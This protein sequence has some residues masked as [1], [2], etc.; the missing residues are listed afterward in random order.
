M[1]KRSAD[2][3]AGVLHRRVFGTLDRATNLELPNSL[4]WGPTLPNY[5]EGSSPKLELGIGALP[6]KQGYVWGAEI[7]KIAYN[8][9]NPKEYTGAD[10][11]DFNLTFGVFSS[12]ASPITTFCNANPGQANMWR[13]D[14]CLDTCTYE[15][16][17][18]G[19]TGAAVYVVGM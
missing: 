13:V 15:Y 4:Y 19:M 11:P 2:Y 5:V 17:A 3:P 6:R 14:Q 9:E 1:T 12:N 18:G 7:L 16:R 10:W 8:I